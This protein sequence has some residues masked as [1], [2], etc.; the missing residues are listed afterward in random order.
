MIS[1]ERQLKRDRN[2]FSFATILSQSEEGGIGAVTTAIIRSLGGDSLHLGFYGA[3][4][5]VN[6]FFSWTGTLL[7]KAF[8]SYRRAMLTA[9]LIGCLIT[10]LIATVILLPRFTPAFQPFSL[11]SYLALVIIFSGLAGTIVNIE[12]AWIGD[13]VPKQLLGWFTSYKV[14]ISVAGGLFFSLLFARVSDLSPGPVAYAGIY[15]MFFLSFLVA[16]LLYR[17]ITDRTPLNANF[18]SEGASHHERLNYRSAPLWLMVTHI[19][20][21]YTGRGMMFTFAAAYLMDQF[22]CSLTKVVLLNIGG[23]LVGILTLLFLGKASDRTGPR[24]P[25]ILINSIVA[26]ST[27]LWV[28]TAWLGV[29]PV[30]IFYII[31]GV[32]GPVTAMLTTNYTLVLY[33]AKGRSGYLAVGRFL[34]SIF[35]TIFVVATGGI[36][37]MLNDWHAVVLGVSLNNYHLMFTVSAIVTVVAVLPLIAIGERTVKEG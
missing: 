34:P 16:M 9:M 29:V 22:H 17:A 2:R 36:L 37:R 13:L 23:P 18:F 20:L 31:S 8:R 33:P 28:S 3:T 26:F 1:D 11:W 5:S 35:T 24:K 21:W 25:L 15:M 12:S 10:A 6:L 4:G 32:G 14:I 19:C 30:V 27:F 7:L